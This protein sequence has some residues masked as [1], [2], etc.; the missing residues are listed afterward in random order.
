MINHIWSVLCKESIINQ[1]DNVMTLYGI[2]EEVTIN[3]VPNSNNPF[4]QENKVNLPI[5]YEVVSYW[6]TSKNIKEAKAKIEIVLL[7]PKGEELNKLNMDLVIPVNF[8]RYR[9]RAKIA[10]LTVQNEGEY[11]IKVSIKNEDQTKFVK[12][13]E[14]PLDI[15]IK[16][17]TNQQI[18]SQN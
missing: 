7:N 16:F 3:L 15:K 8:K 12:V 4:N 14:I 10:G 18:I 6:V 13:A 11:I 5:N 1:E 9:S 2:L 17:E